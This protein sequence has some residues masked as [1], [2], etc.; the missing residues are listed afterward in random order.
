MIG[1]VEVNNFI[2]FNIEDDD[3]SGIVFLDNIFNNFLLEFFIT[4]VILKM[5]I[6]F[7]YIVLYRR[8]WQV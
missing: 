6:L 3:K 8:L 1:N 7:F 2:L 4:D 5:I